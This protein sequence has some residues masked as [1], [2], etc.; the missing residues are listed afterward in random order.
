LHLDGHGFAAIEA[1]LRYVSSTWHVLDEVQH[2]SPTTVM[3]P[4]EQQPVSFPLLSK[5]ESQW[6]WVEVSSALAVLPLNIRAAFARPSMA[7]NLQRRR[8]F[9]VDM[10]CSFE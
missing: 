5:Q 6:Y 9:G 2:T 1:T 10:I 7:T 8:E 3:Q 4:E